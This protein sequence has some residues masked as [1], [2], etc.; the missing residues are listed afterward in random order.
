MHNNITHVIISIGSGPM[1]KTFYKKIMNFDIL[2][3]SAQMF[4]LYLV[5]INQISIKISQ[6]PLKGE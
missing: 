6:I 2:F 1:E 3:I 5:S 4:I